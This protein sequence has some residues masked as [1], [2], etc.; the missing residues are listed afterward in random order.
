MPRCLITGSTGFIGSHV[1][2]AL[3][4]LG[5]DL[6]EVGRRQSSFAREGKREF[7]SWSLDSSSPGI[8][9]VTADILVHCAWD[10]SLPTQAQNRAVNFEGS[11]ALF[12]QARASGVR[13]IIFI[14]SSSAFDG[15]VSEYG[16]SKRALD[17]EVLK[18]GGTVV[19]PGLVWDNAASGGIIASLCSLLRK[20]SICPLPARDVARV[21]MCHVDDLSQLIAE[22]CH[23][24][25]LSPEVYLAAHNQAISFDVVLRELA[26]ASHRPLFL[27]PLP[28][29]PLFSFIR[30]LETMGFRSRFKSDSL[31]NLMTSP[32]ELD[33]SSTQRFKTRFRPF[34]M[35]N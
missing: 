35:S 26:Y 12:A 21:F 15:A 31:L 34:K 1:A 13:K 27:L 9:G 19:R 18:Q 7:V 25:I 28:W 20:S 6:I 29:R 17:I 23:D 5:W 16:K 3:E 4:H 2:L 8:E 32:H 11:L 14:S 22:I 10:F 24:D 30:A 33:F